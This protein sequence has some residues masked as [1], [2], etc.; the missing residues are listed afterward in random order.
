MT[1]GVCQAC[2]NVGSLVY[3]EVTGEYVCTKCKATKD[4]ASVRLGRKVR[5]VYDMRVE[6][7]CLECT[8]CD[9]L[10]DL[11]KTIYCNFYSKP[12]TDYKYI[13]NHFKASTQ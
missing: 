8:A 1:I 10:R 4:S 3:D 2:W 5:Q 12:F 6:Y 13:C 11:N 7:T 9:D